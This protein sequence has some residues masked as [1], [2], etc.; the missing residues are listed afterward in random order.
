MSTEAPSLDLIVVDSRPAFRLAPNAGQSLLRF[1]M[2]SQM[3]QPYAESVAASWAEIYCKPAVDS[4]L[5]FSGEP[6]NDED[7]PPFVELAVR[8]GTKAVELEYPNGPEK[9]AFFL[10]FR[11]C[12]YPGIAA[13]FK[14]RLQTM[15]HVQPAT[16][17]RDHQGVPEHAEVP[18]DEA[19]PSKTKK[20][21]T[22][23]RVGISV[24]EL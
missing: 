10:E 6:V 7:G 13:K 3:A 20:N 2:G 9:T 17:S 11:G 21:S 22:V 12:R 18:E 4:H 1:L 14:T 24:E 8:L 16:H 5:L 23:G 19:P 15:L